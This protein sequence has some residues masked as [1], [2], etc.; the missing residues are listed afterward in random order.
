[1]V[2]YTSSSRWNVARS[3]N[4]GGETRVGCWEHETCYCRD[5]PQHV[6]L[7][8]QVLQ[9][10]RASC[11][12]FTY[13]LITWQWESLRY[14]GCYNTCNVD[15]SVNPPAQITQRGF[16]VLWNA[17]IRFLRTYHHYNIHVPTHSPPVSTE[18][19][20]HISVNRHCSVRKCFLVY[21]RFLNQVG[22]PNKALNS[23]V[24]VSR[25]LWNK[26]AY[27]LVKSLP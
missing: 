15:T 5:T 19:R 10:S 18:N 23:I 8:H 3:H 27:I 6:T 9:R 1:V 16:S 13:T 7:P 17:G 21:C 14:T 11:S 12:V 4:R 24:T 25:K 2:T 22:R 20:Q 26:W